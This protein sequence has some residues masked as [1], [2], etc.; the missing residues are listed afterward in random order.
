MHFKASHPQ[1]QDRRALDKI[2]GYMLV[3]VKKPTN[4]QSTVEKSSHTI[5]CG[6]QRFICS[7]DWKNTQGDTKVLLV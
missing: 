3:V 6:T 5:C 7:S 2:K 4:I 1:F